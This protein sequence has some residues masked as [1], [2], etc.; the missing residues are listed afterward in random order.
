MIV[1]Y[2]TVK[3]FMEV[4]LINQILERGFTIQMIDSKTKVD[5]HAF[6]KYQASLN[7]QIKKEVNIFPKYYKNLF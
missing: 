1:L 4:R 2:I 3:L 5:E 6:K 7:E